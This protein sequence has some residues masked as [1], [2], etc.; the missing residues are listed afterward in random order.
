MDR[1]VKDG[2]NFN[3]EIHLQPILATDYFVNS[4]EEEER[5]N[6]TRK[7]YGK[8]MERERDESR[9]DSSHL[10]CLSK[11]KCVHNALLSKLTQ[12]DDEV[13][14]ILSMDLSLYDHQKAAIGGLFDEFIFSARLD[15]LLL[16]FCAMEAINQCAFDCRSLDSSTRTTLDNHIILSIWYDHEEVGSETC[17]GAQSTLL[18]S[19]LERIIK[20]T[21]EKGKGMEETEMI[22]FSSLMSKSVLISADMAHGVH[23]N[24]PE[25]HDETHRPK[26]HHG[27]VIKYNSNARYATST[28]TA[29]LIKN[30]S[31]ERSIPIQ[32]F[33]VRNDSPCGSTIGPIVSSQLG[34]NSIGKY[35]IFHYNL[36]IIDLGIAQLSMHSIREMA[37][38][39]DIG[40]MIDLFE[41]FYNRSLN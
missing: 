20:E 32:E 13:E 28:Y 16:S 5:S 12:S 11:N 36:F 23:P 27:P 29:A 10:S 6:G 18:K 30:I 4:L 41:I 38:I 35:Y 39:T 19:C 34:I 2:F 9:H 7:G 15:N 3:T 17:T 14:G 33:M 21:L 22:D 37:G 24:Y 25:K 26:I 31:M 40:Y 8:N 1:S